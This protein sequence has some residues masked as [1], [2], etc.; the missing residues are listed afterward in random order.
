MAVRFDLPPA[1]RNADY[2]PDS[3]LIQDQDW[4]NALW[5]MEW[6]AKPGDPGNALLRA[7]S[8]NGMLAV[9]RETF[10]GGRPLTI[11]DIRIDGTALAALP[12]ASRPD[13]PVTLAYD[14]R[15]TP[16]GQPR[17]IVAHGTVSIQPGVTA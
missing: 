17:R 5:E 11:A 14:I 7:T 4:S 9:R 3:I 12:V 15:V 2:R 8:A 13:R 6:R 16:S 1:Q 10:D